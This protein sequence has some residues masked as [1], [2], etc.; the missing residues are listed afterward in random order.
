MKQ[1]PKQTDC[2]SVW[3]LS[4]KNLFPNM[5]THLTPAQFKAI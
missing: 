5:Q 3:Q 2:I 1:P 4:I